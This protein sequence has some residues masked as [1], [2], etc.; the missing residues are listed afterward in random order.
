MRINKFITLLFIALTFSANNY[1]QNA[2]VNANFNRNNSDSNSKIEKSAIEIKKNSSIDEKKDNITDNSKGDKDIAKKLSDKVF[3]STTKIKGLLSKIENKITEIR[4]DSEVKPK[5]L[6]DSSAKNKKV[7]KYN[8][9]DNII[10]DK[11]SKIDLLRKEYLISNDVQFNDL[12]VPSKKKINI[13]SDK[14]MHPVPILSRY[15]TYDNRHIPL[16]STPSNRIDNLFNA[17]THRNIGYFNS[18]YKYVDNPNIFNKYGDNLVTYSIINNNHATLS[19]ILNRGA[20]PNI[21]NKLGYTPVQIAIE[22]ND[23]ESLKILFSNGAD[24][25]YT[26]AF[27][28]NYLMY[29][30]RKGMLS[31]IDYLV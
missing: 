16:I 2:N 31:V 1:A 15:R 3:N 25:N 23:F 30:S 8:K 5:E 11:P 10:E 27:G 4:D 22:L 17:I 20:N 9:K 29:A 26:D 12:T 18:A 19:S 21:A 13:F 28:R 7:K 14:E 24:L 6:Q